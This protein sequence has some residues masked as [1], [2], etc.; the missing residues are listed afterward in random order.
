MERG[1][2]THAHDVT[3]Q[4][5]LEW[6]VLV[7]T[8]KPY[9]GG[10][11][12]PSEIFVASSPTAVTMVVGRDEVVLLDA[13]MTA[14]EAVQL[15]EWIEGTGKRL[16][17]IYAT[18]G[19]GDHWFCV[20][21]LLKR[22]PGARFV[23]TAETVDYMVDSLSSGILDEFWRKRFP[24]QIPQELVV[25][26]PLE[27]DTFVVEGHAFDIYRAG[28][29]DTHDTTYVHVPD[30]G[31]VAGGDVVYNDM[32]MF[33]GETTASTRQNWIES[34][35]KVAALDPTIVVAGHKKPGVGDGPEIVEQT[36]GY[37]RDMDDVLATA[38]TAREVYDAMLLRHPDRA[39]PMALWNSAV[40][41]TKS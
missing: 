1:N 18:H 5:A 20:G 40:E 2:V 14:A 12:T 4:S 11:E 38:S 31:L 34:L 13:L 19:H 24:E 6:E 21:D 10:P 27:A 33:L 7:V 30:L 15:S 29:T 23:A 26:E 35:Q 28:H 3:H 9:V 25:A 32:H 8:G 16:S 36:I 17:T 39:N 22:H 41:L 37:L